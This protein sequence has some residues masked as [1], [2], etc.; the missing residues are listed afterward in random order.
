MNNL[1]VPEGFRN[2]EERLLNYETG[3]VEYYLT[4]VRLALLG[5]TGF[6]PEVEQHIHSVLTRVTEKVRKDGIWGLQKRGPFDPDIFPNI[7]VEFEIRVVSAVMPSSQV[8]LKPV[9]SG[10]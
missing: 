9:E 2:M 1:A 10:G 6:T 8:S 7:S 3:P 5:D 4:R